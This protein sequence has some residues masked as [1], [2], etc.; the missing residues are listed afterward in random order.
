MKQ[1]PRLGLII[2]ALFVVT[3]VAQPLLNC[4]GSRAVM[5]VGWV[6]GWLML[7]AL[8]GLWVWILRGNRRQRLIVISAFVAW[9]LFGRAVM[10]ESVRLCRPDLDPDNFTVGPI[11][12]PIFNGDDRPN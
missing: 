6:V 1:P 12:P 5:T 3:S 8:F 9:A 7:P 4:A 10:R 11:A 2:I